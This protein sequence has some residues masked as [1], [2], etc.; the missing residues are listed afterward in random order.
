MQDSLPAP[1][2]IC[3]MMEM[4]V[5]TI[6]VLFLTCAIRF[7]WTP[8]RSSMSIKH[9]KVER[10]SSATSLAYRCHVSNPDYHLQINTLYKDVDR[11]NMIPT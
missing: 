1:L 8:C 10:H 3:D 4:E 5:G 9:E 6:G 7:G 2:Q 11:R